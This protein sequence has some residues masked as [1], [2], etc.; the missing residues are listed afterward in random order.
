MSIYGDEDIDHTPYRNNKR[1]LVACSTSRT[2]RETQKK[3]EDLR[4]TRIYRYSSMDERWFE[5]C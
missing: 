2:D 5:R 4:I 1:H 3:M